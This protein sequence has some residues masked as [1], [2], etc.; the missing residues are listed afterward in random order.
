MEEKCIVS[1]LASFIKEINKHWELE[2]RQM[3]YFRGQANEA[4]ELI[5]GCA[6]DPHCLHDDEMVFNYWLKKALMYISDKNFYEKRPIE[7]LSIA[8]HHGLP[9]RL[10]DWSFNPLV[11]LFFACKN[12]CNEPGAVYIYKNRSNNFLKTTLNT[13]SHNSYITIDGK[14]KEIAVIIPTSTSSR[15]S[16]QS[17]LFTLHC[18]PNKNII[19]LLEKNDEIIKI[20]IPS[21]AKDHL[22]QELI[23]CGISSAT[24]FPD[25]DGISA[26]IKETNELISRIEKGEHQQK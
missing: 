23:M 19:D 9:T 20:I 14:I 2:Y 3:T 16:A 13:L 1:D 11:A 4:W 7:L 18:K 26:D 24:L 17:G 15:I 10:L 8:Q 6:R 22:T 12:N 25:M 21:A 5:P